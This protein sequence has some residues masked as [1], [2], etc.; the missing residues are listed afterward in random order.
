[1][2]VLIKL[3]VVAADDSAARAMLERIKTS[4]RSVP[5]AGLHRVEFH[6]LARNSV[7]PSSSPYDVI[8]FDNGRER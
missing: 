6:D 4:F 8:Q 2:P 3:E 1:M 5:D 7:N